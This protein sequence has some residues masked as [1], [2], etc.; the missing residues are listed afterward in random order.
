[1]VDDNGGK[2]LSNE[3]FNYLFP[4]SRDRVETHIANYNLNDGLN[5]NGKITIKRHIVDALGGLY[6]AKDGTPDNLLIKRGVHK[7]GKSVADEWFK[8]TVENLRNLIKV[9][10]AYGHIT[11]GTFNDTKGHF[12]IFKMQ[13]DN[14]QF[15]FTTDNFKGFHLNHLYNYGQNIG[16]DIRRNLRYRSLYSKYGKPFNEKLNN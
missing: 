15:K 9:H 8:P 2:Y 5:N 6:N 12:K 7:N 16:I 4:G 1:L 14:P 11:S 10:E 13:I 3:I